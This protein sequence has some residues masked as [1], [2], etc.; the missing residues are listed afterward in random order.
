MYFCQKITVLKEDKQTMARDK[1]HENVREA[2][3]KEGWHITDDPLTFK[4]GKIL[5]Q[6]D[7]GAEL[8]LGAERGT[9]K[10]AVEIKTFGN[11][12]FITALYEAV[13]KYIIYRNVLK[14]IQPERILFLAVP[15]SVYD[16]YFEETVIQRTTQDE[17]FKIV[18]YNQ[19]TQNI[20]QWIEN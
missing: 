10:I 5:V 8:I 3:I 19:L 12:S 9:D 14:I 11:D 17:K 1:F 20:T 16:R 13:G 2:L 7:L 6:I 15:E 18:V 4:V